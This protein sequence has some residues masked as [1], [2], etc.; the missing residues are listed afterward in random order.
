[1][2]E[3][4]LKPAEIVLSSIGWLLLKKGLMNHG[5]DPSLM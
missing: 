1:M 5:E 2:H 3:Q 4:L